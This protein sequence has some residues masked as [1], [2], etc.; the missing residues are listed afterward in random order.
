[1]LRVTS[2]LSC[3]RG[4]AGDRRLNYSA[5][6]FGLTLTLVQIGRRQPDRVA[7]LMAAGICILLGMGMPTLGVYVLL[8][9]LVAPALVE[10]GVDQM[11]AHLFVLYYGMMSMITPPIAIA[12]FAAASLTRADPMRTALAACRFGWLAYVIPFLIVA[13]PTLIMRGEAMEIVVD[14]ATAFIGVWLV[15]VALMGFLVRAL[16]PASRLLFAVTGLAALVPVS[17]FAGAAIVTAAGV[18]LGVVLSAREL[19]L[20]RRAVQRL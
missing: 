13:S 8:A 10:V 9:T 11:A 2:S 3:R 12:A 4:R 14:V 1:M 16:G 15:S 18:A 7:W 19:I 6:S 5:S 20:R 17:A